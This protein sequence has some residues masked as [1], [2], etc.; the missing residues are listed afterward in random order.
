MGVGLVLEDFDR[1][2]ATLQYSAIIINDVKESTSEQKKR[3]NDLIMTKYN[4]DLLSNIPTCECGGVT[5][6]YNLGIICDNCNTECAHVHGVLESLIWLRAPLGVHALINPAAFTILSDHFTKSN[7]NV[8]HWLADS[9][10]NTVA[11]R[12]PFLDYIESF[13]FKR[14]LNYFYENFDAIMEVLLGMKAFDKQGKKNTRDNIREFI[15]RYR[16]CIFCKYVPLPNKAMIVL[17]ET[18]SGIYVDN[19]LTKAIDAIRTLVGI[20]SQITNFTQKVKENR[21]IKCISKLSSFYKDYF[22]TTFAKKE[23]IFRKHIFGTRS[24]FSLR[25]VISS[26][27]DP[28]KYD[29]IYVPWCIAINVLKQHLRNKLTKQGMIPNQIESFLNNHVYQYSPLL[30]NIFKELIAEAGPKGIPCV[31]TRNPSLQRGSCLHLNISR[32]KIDLADRTIS[33]SILSVSS[34]NADF[35]GDEVSVTLDVDDVISEGL[36]RLDPHNGAFD[37]DNYRGISPNLSMPKP[38]IATIG[39]W[40]EMEN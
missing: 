18:N 10:Y 1:V 32:I 6:E 29:E 31:L 3:L 15:T 33:L 17:E 5:G 39:N 25:S 26:I 12:P 7:F 4:S 24:H 2:F 13:G 23:G 28:H 11:K 36:S 27:T 40:L 35:D 9:S 37:F 21:S 30:D 14:G 16:H 19:A 20:D 34:L 22:K 8:I 38:A